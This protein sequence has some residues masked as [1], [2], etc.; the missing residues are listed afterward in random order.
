[1]NLEGNRLCMS[2]FNNIIR[3]LVKQC[4]I[5]LIVNNIILAF[6]VAIQILGRL[7]RRVLWYRGGR[8]YRESSYVRRNDS[9]AH[10]NRRRGK[11]TNRPFRY[12]SGQRR[13]RSRHGAG[14]GRANMRRE[15]GGSPYVVFELA[16]LGSCS[17]KFTCGVLGYR[18]LIRSTDLTL[19]SN[20]P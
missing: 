16:P 5:I 4:C 18:K 3:S 20:N 13:G 8:L 15:R 1:M 2:N 7:V 14:K 12:W 19:V 6:C 9:Y 17:F 10:V 11:W